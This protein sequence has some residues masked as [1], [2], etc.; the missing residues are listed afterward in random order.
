MLAV[1]IWLGVLGYTS[2]YYG[3][4]L[5]AGAPVSFAHALGLGGNAPTG[6]AAAAP[7]N[8]ASARSSSTPSGRPPVVA[9]PPVTV[10]HGA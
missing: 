1:G 8:A 5:W 4:K 3:A 6:A 9:P 7:G 2:L 10:P